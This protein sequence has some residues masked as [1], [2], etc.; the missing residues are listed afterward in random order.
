[1]SIIAPQSK[2]EQ[3]WPL[4]AKFH[5]LLPDF[6]DAG[7]S[8]Y[9]TMAPNA[10][11]NGTTV[12]KLDLMLFFVNVTDV[13][14]MAAGVKLLDEFRA[15]AIK[16]Q[17]DAK[18]DLVSVPFV[19]K[20]ISGVLQAPP[21]ADLTGGRLV[22]GSRLI[23]RDFLLKPTGPTELINALR[24]ISNVHPVAYTGHIVAGGAVAKNEVDS[25]INPAWRKTLTHIVFGRIWVANA[26]LAEQQAMQREV[27]AVEVE[28]LRK[29]EPHMGAYVN[30]ADANEK[31][32]QT[33]FWGSNYKRLYRIKQ[34]VDPGNIFI[35]RRGVGSEDWDDAGLCRQYS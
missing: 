26:T 35:A 20:T 32:F 9:Y 10:D 29:L 5:Q 21:K 28:R 17:P 14:D 1:M 30:E 25:A 7:M 16:I 27:T 33:S 24:D 4:V 23:S 18:Y 13:T 19:S 6:S 22:L 15:E 31:D 34:R 2:V 8:G 12:A 11:V 3:Y